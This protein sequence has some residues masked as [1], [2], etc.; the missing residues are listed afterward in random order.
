MCQKADLSKEEVETQG[1]KG[2]QGRLPTLPSKQPLL[3]VFPE[4]L[5]RHLGSPGSGPGPL[6]RGQ[7]RSL[8]QHTKLCTEQREQLVTARSQVAAP[9][10]VPSSW[11]CACRPGELSPPWAVHSWLSA[12]SGRGAPAGSEGLTPFTLHPVPGQT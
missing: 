6:L 4:P 3:C 10:H 1:I 2:G 8:G 9:A 7:D 5:L 12:I 11:T